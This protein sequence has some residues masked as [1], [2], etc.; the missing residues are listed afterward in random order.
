MDTFL[1]IGDDVASPLDV[2]PVSVC[3]VAT[4]TK[5]LAGERGQSVL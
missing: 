1:S 4:N 3:R 2:F 5:A